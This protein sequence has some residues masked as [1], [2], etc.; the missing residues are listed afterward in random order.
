MLRWN[1]RTAFVKLRHMTRSHWP[2][3]QALLGFTPEYARSIFKRPF[4]V[5][6]AEEPLKFGAI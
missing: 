6:I 4:D 3:N 1:S 5:I 2:F